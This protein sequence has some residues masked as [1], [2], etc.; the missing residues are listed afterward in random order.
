MSTSRRRPKST[1]HHADLRPALLAAARRMLER[2]GP[3]ALSLREVARRAGVSHNAPYR[4][5]ADRAALLAAVAAEGFDTLAARMHEAAAKAAPE[6]RLSAI[7]AAYVRFALDAP[8]LFRLMFGGLVRGADHADL[9]AAGAR[10][11]AV[12]A[13][14]AK[15]EKPSPTRAVAAWATVHGLAH[16]LLE[17]QIA[18]VR[19]NPTATDRL[20]AEILGSAA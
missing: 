2:D 8:N 6:R 11:Y 4:H 15:S 1:Y 7:G 18:A 19:D 12:L 14:A 10:A 3:A 16:L 17:G 9:A 5:F 13:G 20:I